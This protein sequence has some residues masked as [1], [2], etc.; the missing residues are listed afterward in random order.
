MTT[1]WKRFEHQAP[2]LADLVRGRFQSTGLGF[3]ATLRRDG[4]P[5]VSGIEPLVGPE[6]VL[7]GMM[8]RSLKALDLQRDPRCALHS[9]S[10]DKA[11]AE[12]DARISGRA[13]EHTDDR[14]LAAGRQAFSDATGHPPP[15]GPMHLFTIDITEVM[16][17]CVERDHLVVRSWTPAGGERRVERS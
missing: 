11:V 14:A 8:W 6:D 4:S 10:I 16:F 17:L 1:N 13:V 3:L 5:R 15:E 2:E 9:A 7:M 12:G